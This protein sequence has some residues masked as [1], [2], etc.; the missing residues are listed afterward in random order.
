MRSCRVARMSLSFKVSLL[1]VFCFGQEWLV[2]RFV[3]IKGS[4][5]HLRFS[6]L[7]RILPERLLG[8]IFF[9]VWE[10]Y[11][12][13]N[14]ALVEV[15][16]VIFSWVLLSSTVFSTCRFHTQCQK[17]ACAQHWNVV[18]DFCICSIKLEKPGMNELQMF[19]ENLEGI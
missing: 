5:Y 3:K 12:G 19:S 13:W 1:P 18:C 8:T 14:L 9:L 10:F 6:I 2:L 17:F 16:G 11:D 15:H 4:L 7:T